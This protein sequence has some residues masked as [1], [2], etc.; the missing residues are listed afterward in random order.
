MR[1]NLS[2][3]EKAKEVRLSHSYN[4][5]SKPTWS[6]YSLLE[7]GD[8]PSITDEQFNRLFELA[9][10]QSPS[11]NQEKEA[12]KKDLD[13]ISHFLEQIQR[14][15]LENV[16]PLIQLWNQDT[17]LR[18]RDDVP[19]EEFDGRSLLKHAKKTVDGYYAVEGKVAST[20]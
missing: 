9:Q 14:L 5:P 7:S 2:L 17:G 13:Q 16:E 12:L 6:I 8:R 18:L 1:P 15:D 4:K 10:L 11:S 20:E 3:S 19:E